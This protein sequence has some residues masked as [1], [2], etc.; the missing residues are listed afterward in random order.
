MHSILCVV[1]ALQ[2]QPGTVTFARRI[3]FSKFC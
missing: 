3:I 2:R 1:H